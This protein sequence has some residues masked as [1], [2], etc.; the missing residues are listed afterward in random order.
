MSADTPKNGTAAFSRALMAASLVIGLLGAT[1]GVAFAV[2]PAATISALA[3][4]YAEDSA[5]IHQELRDLN[6]RLGQME[7]R[8]IAGQRP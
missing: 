4:R 6:T 7:G 5:Q 1:V 2:G 8:I 3:D